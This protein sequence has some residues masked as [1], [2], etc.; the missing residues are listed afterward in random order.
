MADKPLHS[1]LPPLN[2]LRGF[3]AAARLGSFSK[4][5]SELCITQSAVSHQIKALEDYFGQPLF[6]RINRAVE[7]TDAGRDFLKT[8]RQMLQQLQHGA[9]RLHFYNKPGLVV[10]DTSPAFASKWLLPRLS[11]F[12]R[13]YQH[14]NPWIY[15]NYSQEPLENAEVDLAIWFGTGEW[16]NVNC[17]QL[18]CDEVTPLLSPGLLPANMSKM[19][20]TDIVNFPLIHVEQVERRED[21]RTWFAK[22]GLHYEP[23]T[24]GY[25]F[26]DSGIALDFAVAG[27]GIVLGSKLL[28]ADLIASNQLIAP[29]TL[30]VPTEQNYFLIEKPGNT[31]NE[32]VGLFR[33]WLLNNAH[34]DT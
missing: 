15:T 12:K 25:N 11:A 2:A 26:N 27:Q 34:Q 17:T 21:W 13:Q 22:A 31:T 29:F 5:S 18:F 8:T 10:L 3:E 6:K 19:A 4:A 20:H 14:V 7:L 30:S 28:A 9:N 23:S 1:R 32:N 33:N 24:E 16:T